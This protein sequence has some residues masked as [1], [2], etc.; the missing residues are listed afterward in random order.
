M[1]GRLGST[2]LS[3]L[4][5]HRESNPNFPWKKSQWENK[6]VRIIIIMIMIIIIIIIYDGDDDDDDDD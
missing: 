3:R 5:F 1:H 6:I 4:V 2:T